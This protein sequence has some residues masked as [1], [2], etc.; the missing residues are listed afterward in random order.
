MAAS[1]GEKVYSSIKRAN[2]DAVW[3]MQGWMFG[4]QRHIWDYETLGA[5]VSRVP[6]DK[7]LLLD[8][9]VDYNRQTVG[10][11][12]DSQYGRKDGNDGCS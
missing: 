1:Y 7:M 11:Q 2:K 9:A 3:V 10:L 12:C 5:L 4:Y 8:L 6:D